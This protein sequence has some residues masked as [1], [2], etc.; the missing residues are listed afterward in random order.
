MGEKKKT[1]C[2]VIYSTLLTEVPSYLSILIYTLLCLFSFSLITFDVGSIHLHKCKVDLVTWPLFIETAESLVKYEVFFFLRI[3]LFFFLI[4]SSK[5][6]STL[7]FRLQAYNAHPI[8]RRHLMVHF[9][10]S[11]ASLCRNKLKKVSFNIVAILSTG[12]ME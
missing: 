2:Y 12:W 3:I 7:K 10:F 5:A 8:C 4:T 9:S 1:F 11:P 6:P